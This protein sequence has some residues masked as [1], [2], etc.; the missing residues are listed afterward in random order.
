M[1][2]V[3]VIGGGSTY[4]PE[5]IQGFLARRGRLPVGEVWLVD[6]DPD[7]LA[8]VGG[9]TARMVAA[10]G[11]PFRVVL[12]G[13]RRAAISGADYVVTQ[14][15]VGRMAAREGDEQLGRRHGLVGQETTG[16]GGFA[17]ALR[18]VPVILEIAAEIA[19]E[20][21]AA[22]LV[23]F[24][25][26]AGLVTEALFRH[27]PQVRAVGVCNGPPHLQM[28][29]LAAL[30]D[31]GPAI[32]PERSAL[33]TL[34][35]N[36]LGWYRGFRL[37][38]RDLW[39]EVMDRWIRRMRETPDPAWDPDLLAALGM[40]PNSYLRYFYDTARVVDEQAGSPT[41]ASTVMAIEAELLRDYA[42]PDRVAPPATLMQRGG[43]YY[44]TVATQLI[45]AHH[46]GRGTTHIV[47]VRHAGAVPGW[48]PSWVLELPARVDRDGI[49]PIPTEPL[50]AVVAG[51]LHHVK[52]YELLAVEAAVHGDPRVALQALIAHP[53][54]PSMRRAEAL[55]EDLLQTNATYLPRFRTPAP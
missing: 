30:A 52:A 13:D 12:T 28:E 39:P 2:K 34:G 17:K 15:R 51:L 54:G 55:L 48:D 11:G 31:G 49:H 33:E 9:L 40:I 1:I 10:A 21:P 38:G 23:N 35:L 37:D 50:P 43:A 22:L 32:D 27:A 3:A 41:R 18:T 29:I 5:L 24:T 36:H 44:S 6:P 53:L 20:A 7:R 26:P 8:V 45:D 42:D 25:N 4:T 47:N 46:N 19:A 16:V 14:L